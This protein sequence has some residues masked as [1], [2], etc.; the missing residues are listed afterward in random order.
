M[1]QKI[2]SILARTYEFRNNI[3]QAIKDAE[4]KIKKSPK[5]PLPLVSPSSESPVAEYLEA[6]MIRVVW[7]RSSMHLRTTANDHSSKKS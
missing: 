1:E 2:E 7:P 4:K 3:K 6:G 5:D